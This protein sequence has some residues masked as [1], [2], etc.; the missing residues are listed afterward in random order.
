MR[1]NRTAIGSWEKFLVVTAGGGRI[2]LKGNNNKFV[3]S[4]DGATSMNCNRN[5]ES[6]LEWLTPEVVSTGTTVNGDAEISAA[7]GNASLGIFNAIEKAGP[8]GTVNFSGSYT[9]NSRVFIKQPGVTIRGGTFSTPQNSTIFR[10]P[11]VAGITFENIELSG[12]SNSGNLPGFAALIELEGSEDVT[13]KDCLLRN[14]RAGIFSLYKPSNGLRVINSDFIDCGTGF[15]FNRDVT[16]VNSSDPILAATNG[17]YHEF[18]NCVFKGATLF[19]PISFDAGN[20]GIYTYAG[21]PNQDSPLR[22]QI[23]KKHTFLYSETGERSKI[24]GCTIGEDSDSGGIKSFG[25][26]MAFIDGLNIGGPTSAERNYLA[27]GLTRRPF[28]HTIHFEHSTQNV[29]IENNVIKTRF[30]KGISLVGFSDHGSPDGPEFGASNVTIKNNIFQGN[31]S[32]DAAAL[33]G[34]KFHNLSIIDN[35][36]T[37]YTSGRNYVFWSVP[38]DGYGTVSGNNPSF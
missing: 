10:I 1:C 8:G 25:V 7:G 26:A 6:L 13:V 32:S 29:L 18:S 3:S 12:P 35:S 23:D 17:G 20:D 34:T 28:A 4:E 14:H 15:A 31:G 36:M 11:D 33:I 21:F 30:R 37:G 27:M 2:A 24:V 16:R 5:S 19:T 38:T 22:Q 9:V